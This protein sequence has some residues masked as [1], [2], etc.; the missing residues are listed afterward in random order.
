MRSIHFTEEHDLFRDAV[1]GFFETEVAPHADAWEEARRIPREIWPKMAERGFLGIL[2]PETYGGTAADIFYAVAFLEELPRSRMGG[3]A[4][5]VTVQEFI[6]TGAILRQGTEEQ[7][8]R[9]LVPSIEG[10]KVGA[11]CIS[12]PDTGSDVAAIRT[13]AVRDGDSFIVNGAKTWITNG[14]Y[15]DFYVVAVKTD[16][17]AGAQGISL[18]AFDSDLPGIRATKLKKMGWHSSDTAEIVFEDVRVPASSLVGRENMGFFYIMQT[19]ALERISAAATGVGGALLALEETK[20]YMESRQAFGRPI[21]KFQALRHR[22]ADLATEVEA[23]RQLVYHTAWLYQQGEPAI[24]ESSMAKLYSSELANRVVDACVQMYGGFGYVEEYPMARFYRD[25]RVGTIVA[26][27]SEIMR[28]IIAKVEIDGIRFT[29]IE[30]REPVP[31]ITSVESAPVTSSQDVAAPAAKPASGGPPASGPLTLAS[32]FESLPVRIRPERTEGWTSRFHFTFA[33]SATPEW[34]VAIDGAACTVSRGL[35]GTPDCSVR[36]TEEVYLGIETGKQ[37]PQAAYI[38]G[39]VKISN[40][41]EMM[42][43]IKSFKPAA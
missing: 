23:A 30:D 1:R 2:F 3:F 11:I 7:K 38:T 13:S 4:A 5:A 42:R 19:F 8:Q 15:G 31:E 25:A 37:N 35:L 26:G 40:L 20:K 18:L 12:E 32:L 6:A 33:G 16:P 28:E 34:T 27:T 22:L 36:T 9:Y 41:S 21:A 24:R 17:G 10:R 43:Y 39:K 29:S 14:V